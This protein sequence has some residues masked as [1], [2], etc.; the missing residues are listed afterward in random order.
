L[1][2][3]NTEAFGKRLGTS[4][5]NIQAMKSCGRL[6]A[7]IDELNAERR[8]ALRRKPAV[9]QNN[10]TPPQIILPPGYTLACLG[11]FFLTRKAFRQYVQPVIADMQEEYIVATKAGDPWHARWIILRGHLLVVP[12]WLYAFV[13][14]R[15]AAL[16][17]RE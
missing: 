8:K 16:W 7:L 3:V 4:P 5:L 14:G 10:P 1:K 2:R 13:G 12:G 15:L 6:L 9:C 17:R 11:R